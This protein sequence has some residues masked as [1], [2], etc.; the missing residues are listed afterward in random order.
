MS[1]QMGYDRNAGDYGINATAQPTSPL[2]YSVRGIKVNKLVMQETGTY[3]DMYVRPYEAYMDS[4]TFNALNNRLDKQPISGFSGSTF[5]GLDNPLLMPTATHTGG[6]QIPY[7]WSQK[8]IVFMMEVEILM[9]IGEVAVYFFQ[10]YTDYPGVSPTGAIDPHM[11][12]IIN[13]VSKMKS[14]ITHTPA[15]TVPALRM[16]ASEQ[17][18]SDASYT[19]PMDNTM[20]HTLRPYDIFTGMEKSYSGAYET[21]NTVDFRNIL[22]KG[23]A[24][25]KRT[26][27]IPSNYLANIFDVH[28]VSNMMATYGDGHSNILSRAVIESAE[29]SLS[30]NPFIMALASKSGINSSGTFKYGDLIN[31]DPGVTSRTTITDLNQEARSNLN[32]AGQSAHWSGSDR[33]TVASTVL[34]AAVP[35]LMASLCISH[36]RLRTTNHTFDGKFE[37]AILQARG[38]TE[39]IDLRPYIAI[40]TSRLESEVLMDITSGSQVPITLDMDCKIYGDT[41]IDIS[42]TG[43]SPTRFVAATLCDSLTAPVITNNFDHYRTLVTNIEQLSNIVSDANSSKFQ[44][45]YSKGM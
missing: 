13:S 27:N 20:H 4:T 42:F 36:V 32:L 39:T 37:T 16:Q 6:I 18:L 14:V 2:G 38:I 34:A 21:Q 44:T 30:D 10:G 45:S 40:F 1:T 31:I 19:G 15:G 24:L 3:N 5:A 28:N 43:A 35:S 22:R 8:R 25:S 26:N 11:L 29:S 12:F 41:V 9:S 17:Y 33:E 7:G 23:P